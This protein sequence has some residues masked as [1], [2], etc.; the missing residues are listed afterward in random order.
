MNEMGVGWRHL[1][2]GQDEGHDEAVE[3]QHLS[4]DQDQD[5]AHE[6]P[7]LLSGASHSSV[8]H[9]ANG[10]SGRQT[11]QAHAQTCP[12]MQEAPDGENA[13][14]RVRGGK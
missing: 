6:E 7:R 12:K 14:V 9:D 13:D 1:F 8:A 5:H 10:E 2:C 3:P 11:A 4:E